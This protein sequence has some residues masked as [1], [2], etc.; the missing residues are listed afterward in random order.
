MKTND[1]SNIATLEQLR[2]V[3]RSLLQEIMTSRRHLTGRVETSIRLF[4]LGKILLPVI[5]QLRTIISGTSFA[6]F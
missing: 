6:K 4:S 5:K 3:R 1:F 2:A